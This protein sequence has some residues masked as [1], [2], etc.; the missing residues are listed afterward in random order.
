[1]VVDKDAS[2]GEAEVAVEAVGIA[3]REDGDA[4]G[5]RG[6][7]A[8]VVADGVAGGDKLD[9]RDACFEAADGKESV[10]DIG[11]RSD[12]VEADAEAHHIELG[13]GEADDAR[14]VE[15]VS[16]DGRVVETT[17]EVVAPE[18]ELVDLG[19]GEGI[20]VGV[21]AAGEV[22]EDRGDAEREVGGEEH[23]GEMGDVGAI[24]AEAV[25]AGVELDMDRERGKGRGE[26]LGGRSETVED[27]E[28]VDIGF[29]VVLDDIVETILLGVH[30]HD[31]EG[32]AVAAEFDALVGI[33]DGE[34][35]DMIELERV[36]YLDLAGSVRGSL[37]H[38]HKFGR[39]SDTAAEEVEVVDESVDVDF[40]DRFVGATAEELG[41]AFEAKA[42]GTF[43]EDDFGM[44]GSEV[45][46]LKEGV[47]VGDK[48]GVDAMEESA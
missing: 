21:L 48:E 29:E 3:D 13:V 33:G 30:D 8:A 28:A 31:R 12:A 22:R 1:M 45:D 6:D 39:G 40:H 36:G 14:R 37:D 4:R 38:R 19:A 18:R 26:E 44:E 11:L 10:L 9:L 2:V 5:A 34:V 25:H 32:D 47:G 23:V 16:A 7:P 15:D 27:A 17:A 24:E 42:T 46:L 20:H 35:V 43:E 41:D